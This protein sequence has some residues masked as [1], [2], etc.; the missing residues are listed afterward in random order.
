MLRSKEPIYGEWDCGPSMRLVLNKDKTFEM[1]TPGDRT[2]L[3]VIGDF[4]VEE[5]GRND[6]GFTKFMLT[7]T[8]NSRTVSGQTLTDKYTTKYEIT[9]DEMDWNEFVMINTVT[10]GTYECIRM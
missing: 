2:Q 9:F 10:Y 1:Y 5:K 4:T 7:M 3:D 8:T 6:Y